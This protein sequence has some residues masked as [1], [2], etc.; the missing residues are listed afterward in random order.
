MNSMVMVA[1]VMTLVIAPATAGSVAHARS[2]PATRPAPSHTGKSAAGALPDSVLARVGAHRVISVEDFRRA[3]HLVTPPARPD[4]L[5]PV[6][7]RQFLDLLI[8]KE[9]LGENA[10][11][12]PWVWTRRDSAQVL[13]LA[14][15]LVMKVMLDSAL[16]ATRAERARAGDSVTSPQVL[17]EL[18]RD[19]TVARM[20]PVFDSAV[21]ARLAADWAALPRPSSDSSLMAQLRLL[22]T[23]PVVAP[24]DTARVLV[25][26][27]GDSLTVSA[28]LEA[29]RNINPLTRP[30]VSEPSQM[31]D[32][33]RNV[34]FERL[35]RREA[36]RRGIE[37]RSDIAAAVDR[38]REYVDVS[39]LVEHEVYSTLISD[40]LTL[41]DYYHR[42]AREFD[43]PLRAR[44]LRLAMGTRAEGTAMALRLRS[45]AEA[46]TIEARSARQRLGY[47]MEVAAESDSAL[48]A[49][50]MRAGTGVVLG[51]DSTATGWEVIRITEVL[52]PRPRPFSEVRGQVDTAWYGEEGERRMEALLTRL[53]AATPVTINP[54]ALARL[55]AR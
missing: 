9:V 30:R 36:A 3:W 23:M 53:R 8:G 20:R 24:S 6:A 29:W 34:L 16:Q 5:T 45:A 35:L 49:R 12:K 13:G 28:L 42:H 40:S 41:L 39:H 18:A 52:P 11:G 1:L 38:Q 55:T 7:A 50:V 54:R 33:V 51:P 48:F 44:L 26:V 15:R 37:R 27:T 31:E 2:G 32:L 17:G 25:R 47:V 14:D 21:I 43:L 22:G 19:S 46:E 10:V 4:S